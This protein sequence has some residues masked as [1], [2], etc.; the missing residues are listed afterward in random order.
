MEVIVDLFNQHSGNAEDLKRL[1]LSAWQNGA[2]VVK[3]QLFKS[4]VV[5]DDD[6][7]RYMEMTFD[8]VKDLKSFCDNLGIKFA[9]TPFDK[10]KVDWLEELNVDFHKV[11]SVSAF[12]HP[13]LVEYILSKNKRTI[14]SLGKF[15]K[16]QFPFGHDK[17]IEYMYC[18]SKYPTLLS[19]DKVK[20]LPEVFT[21]N[22][23]YGYS[24]H[25]LGNSIPVLACLRGA[26]IIEKHYTFNRNAQKNCELAHLCSFTP[27]TLRSFVNTVKDY[28]IAGVI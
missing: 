22:S 6:S 20:N 19:D 12:K 11:A 2:D 26:Q 14:I 24:D 17:N 18:I 9:A 27:E 3:I 1:A 5:W 10:E 23:Y 25:T 21:K 13:E 15:D 8:Q 4:E 7:R 16:D 28:K